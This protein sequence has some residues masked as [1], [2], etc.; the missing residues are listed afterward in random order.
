MLNTI[1][2][3]EGYARLTKD[4]YSKFEKGDT[5]WGNNADPQTIAKWSLDDKDAARAELA[6]RRCSYNE[7]ECLVTITEFALEYCEFDE[8]GEWA[9]GSDFDLAEE[10]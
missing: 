6:K 2:L 8:D 7:G 5:I 3:K 10:A 9:S 4:E 1:L